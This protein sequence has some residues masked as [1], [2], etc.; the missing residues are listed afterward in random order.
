MG[1]LIAS[2]L[3]GIGFAF[4]ALQNTSLVTLHA[5]GYSFAFPLFAIVLGAMLIGLF[6]AWFLSAIGWISHTFTLHQK[7]SKINADEHTIDTLQTRIRE[8]EF[9][10]NRLRGEK[11][12]VKTRETE[13]VGPK[14]SF[15]DHFRHSP[16]M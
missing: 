15:F 6:I 11:H 4:L 5:G 16:S 8:L 14:R 2:I 10:N 13:E 12:I 1:I 3:F 7:D 9:E